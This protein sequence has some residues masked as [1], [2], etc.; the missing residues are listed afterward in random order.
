M[1]GREAE[2]REIFN[3]FDSDNSGKISARE[4]VDCLRKVLPKGTSEDD[5]KAVAGVSAYANTL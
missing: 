5:V 1:A 4:L 3:M 2:I